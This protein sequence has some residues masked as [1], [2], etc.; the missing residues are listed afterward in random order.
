MTDPAAPREPFDPSE[1]I[2]R[3]GVV[4]IDLDQA[5]LAT[6]FNLRAAVLAL[7]ESIDRMTE[8]LKSGKSITTA[9]QREGIGAALREFAAKFTGAADAI[10]P[11]GRAKLATPAP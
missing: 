4:P 1:E 7:G 2:T 10:N 6:L 3:P 11:E 8:E 5:M 9:Q